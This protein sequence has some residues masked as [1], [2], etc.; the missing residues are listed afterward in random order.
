M[1]PLP[2]FRIRRGDIEV[3]KTDFLIARNIE[4]DVVSRLEGDGLVNWLQDQFPDKSRNITSAHH[5]EFD[6]LLLP[7]PR[8]TSLLHI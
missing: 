2:N 3:S 8:T 5:L 4:L 7:R 6:R 1:L